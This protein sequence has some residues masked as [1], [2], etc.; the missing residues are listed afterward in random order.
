MGVLVTQCPD[1]ITG[2]LIT[3]A[4]ALELYGTNS[5]LLGHTFSVRPHQTFAVLHS[6]SS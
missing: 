6:Y 4:L 2:L 5:R 1:L 3:D